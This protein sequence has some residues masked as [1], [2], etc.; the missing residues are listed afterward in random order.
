MCLSERR[1]G[2]ADLTFRFPRKWLDRWRDVATATDR[3][4]MKLHGPRN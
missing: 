2:D 1:V 4:I 3:L